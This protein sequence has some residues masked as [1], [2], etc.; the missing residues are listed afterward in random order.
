MKT[1]YYRNVSESN[2]SD[3]PKQQV[4]LI[5]SRCN[6][7]M[8]DNDLIEEKKESALE[9]YSHYVDNFDKYRIF[10]PKNY[11]IHIQHKKFP[12]FLNVQQSQENQEHIDQVLQFLCTYKLAL[13][14]S[15]LNYIKQ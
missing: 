14:R 11:H 12:Y 3:S 10:L 7:K 5:Y 8:I 1:A 2:S 6:I 13:M 15:W 9:Q 4:T